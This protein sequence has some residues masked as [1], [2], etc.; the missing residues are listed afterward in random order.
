MFTGKT[1]KGDDFEYPDIKMFD[2][3]YFEHYK[4]RFKQTKNHICKSRYGDILLFFGKLKKNILWLR[5]L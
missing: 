5:I 3:N 4:E 1:E 2:D